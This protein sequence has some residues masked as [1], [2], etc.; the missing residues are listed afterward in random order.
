MLEMK[1]NCETCGASTLEME[2]AYICSYECSFCEVCTE[3]THNFQC[4]NCNGEL[5]RRPKR[6][7]AI[8][9]GEEK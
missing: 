9:E 6:V 2:T 3:H 1:K 8:E 5:V 4:P 7:V